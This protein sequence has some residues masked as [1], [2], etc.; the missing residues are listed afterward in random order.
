MC[1]GLNQD[2][3]SFYNCFDEDG[4]L[5]FQKILAYKRKREENE[6]FAEEE[7]DFKPLG[8]KKTR[9][10]YPRRDPNLV[11]EDPANILIRLN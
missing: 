10:V 6:A 5:D 2:Y 8:S 1:F 9:K 3:L 4:E 11:S 7:F